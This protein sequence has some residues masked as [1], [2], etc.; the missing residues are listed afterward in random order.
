LD[1]ITHLYGKKE[2]SVQDVDDV[3]I[4]EIEP[5]PTFK[6][7]EEEGDGDEVVDDDVTIEPAHD[8]GR[9]S[10]RFSFSLFP[11]HTFTQ[12]HPLSLIKRLITITCLKICFISSSNN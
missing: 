10:F 4:N 2:L 1:A 11:V 7:D 8:V 12:T 3:N 9:L 6:D 5:G